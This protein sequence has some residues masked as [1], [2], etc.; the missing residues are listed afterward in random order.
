MD[1]RGASPA[2]AAAQPQGADFE[3]WTF[4]RRFRPHTSI[5]AAVATIINETICCQ[6]TLQRYP[7]YPALQQAI[8]L[9]NRPFIAGFPAK[10][11]YLD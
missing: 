4:R 7:E 3:K 10:I 11:V 8:D 6:S 2:P 1:P 5:P 9:I